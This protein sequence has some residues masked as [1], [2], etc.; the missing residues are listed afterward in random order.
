MPSAPGV[1]RRGDVVGSLDVGLEDDADAVRRLER[2]LLAAR[3]R[4]PARGCGATRVSA[5]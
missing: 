5:S 2:A 1:E 3:D 4:R